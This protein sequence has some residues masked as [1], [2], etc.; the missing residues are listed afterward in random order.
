MATSTP[1]R[2][3][4][5]ARARSP[6]TRISQDPAFADIYDKLSSAAAATDQNTQQIAQ[7]QQT[8]QKAISGLQGSV[9]DLQA[10]PALQGQAALSIRQVTQSAYMLATD[11]TLLFLVTSAAICTLPNCRAS[12]GQVFAVK[13][14]AASGASVT[15]NSV[16]NET[17]DG[18]AASTI[19]LAAGKAIVLQSDGSNWVVLSRLT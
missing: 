3:S 15:L 13:N 6:Y 4:T 17:V 9:K 5:T 2:G 11:Y 14:S 19:V 1:A 7:Q 16:G 12:S 10:M 8:A 18:A